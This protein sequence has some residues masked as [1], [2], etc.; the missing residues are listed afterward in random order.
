MKR[1]KPAHV[2]PTPSHQTSRFPWCGHQAFIIYDTA[3]RASKELRIRLRLSSFQDARTLF[4]E[5]A[6][7]Q[8]FENGS[9]TEIMVH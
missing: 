2:E 5:N 9:A 3:Q 1:L 8:T 4:G 7:E 6:T